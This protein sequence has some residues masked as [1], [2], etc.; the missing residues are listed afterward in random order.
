LV[1]EA[2]MMSEAVGDH[3]IHVDRDPGA[4]PIAA[5]PNCCSLPS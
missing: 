3:L 5:G 1:V 2:Q 4:T